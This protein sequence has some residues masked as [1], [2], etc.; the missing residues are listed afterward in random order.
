MVPLSP[1]IA[2]ELDD[3]MKW[4][5]NFERLLEIQRNIVWPSVL[6]LDP[7]Q[8]VPE[9][10]R[11]ALGRQPCERL[12]VSPRRQILLEGKLQL[13]DSGKPQEVYLI[14]FDDL[15]LLTRRKKA[16]SKKVSARKKPQSCEGLCSSK[17]YGI[18]TSITY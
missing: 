18:V 11:P 10:L 15:F 12:I 8:F 1:F 17:Q 2:G 7:K 3:K 4:L 9:F 5:K 14:L 6:E 13:M 16:L